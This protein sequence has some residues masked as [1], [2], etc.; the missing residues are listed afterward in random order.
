MKKYE[1]WIKTLADYQG[2]REN[3]ADQTPESLKL[4]ARLV[5]LHKPTTIIELGTAHGLSTRL[6]LEETSDIPIHCVDASFNAL[7]GT[8]AVLP[9]DLSRLTLHEKWVNQVRL[10]DLWAAEDRVFLYVDVHSAHQHIFKAIPDLPEGSMVIFDDVWYSPRKL[11]TQKAIDSFVDRVVKP[12]I[13]Y[14]AP[15]AIWPR[16]YAPYWK[17][18]A[19]YGF[20]EVP[21][22]AQWCKG[23][24][25]TLHFEKGV[26]V[27]WFTWPKD[28]EE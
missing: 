13:D 12:Q 5:D 26:K 15:K 14:T 21:E 10:Q 25:V 9:V 19:F 4:L 2:G 27:V 11:N 3:F 8:E 28:R 22:L 23:N 1:D 20:T 17:R 7:R 6:W 16:S 18:G 24:K